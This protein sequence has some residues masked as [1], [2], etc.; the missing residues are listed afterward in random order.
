MAECNGYEQCKEEAEKPLYNGGMLKDIKASVSGRDSLTGVG[1]RYRPA[2]ILHN[3]TQ[4]TIYC[5]SS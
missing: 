1:A 2:Y 4:N 3:L 5:F